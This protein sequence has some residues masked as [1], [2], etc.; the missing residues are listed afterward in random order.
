MDAYPIFLRLKGRPCLIV[1]GGDVAARKAEWLQRAGAA[2][3]V[4]AQHLVAELAASAAAGTLRHETA[5]F[6][7]EL[8]CGQTLV[9][10][11]TDDEALARRV[12]AVAQRAGVPVNVVDRLD[13]STFISGALVD[14][15]PVLVAVSTGGAAPVL[16]REI[17]LAIERLLPPRLGDLANLAERFRSAVRAAIPD[18]R[19]RRRFWQRVFTGPVGRAA[20]AGDGAAA[21]RAMLAL[22]NRKPKRRVAAGCVHIVEI[23]SDDPDLLTLRAQR[24]LG[25]ADVVIHDRVGTAILDHARRDAERILAEAREPE[26]IDAQLATLARAGNRVV[27]LKSRDPL[28]ALHHGELGYL[29]ARGITVDVVP[30]VVTA[31]TSETTGLAGSL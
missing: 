30:S 9:I 21:Q 31:A 7:P 5:P 8:V 29:R 15:S 10:A 27:R 20:L 17:R 16:A 11:A 26:L 14:R 3:T 28:L 2:L 4:N 23:G 18:G 19:E 1:G 25:E 13:L 22:V 24:L 6:S 12:S